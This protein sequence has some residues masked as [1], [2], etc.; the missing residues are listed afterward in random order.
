MGKWGWMIIVLVTWVLSECFTLLAFGWAINWDQ[1]GTFIMA[2]L[3]A[4]WTFPTANDKE[5]EA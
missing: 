2:C 4:V 3:I 5:P 1:F